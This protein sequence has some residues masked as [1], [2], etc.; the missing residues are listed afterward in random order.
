MTKHVVISEKVLHAL[1]RYCS[2][3]KERIHSCGLGAF[4]F[5]SMKL[6]VRLT[7]RGVTVTPYPLFPTLQA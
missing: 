7:G 2:E 1:R 5:F 6:T 3:M 4:A